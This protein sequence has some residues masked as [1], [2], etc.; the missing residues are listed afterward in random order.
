VALRTSARRVGDIGERTG[1]ARSG[2]CGTGDA[3]VPPNND[4]RVIVPLLPVPTRR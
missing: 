1:V 3:D 4:G 2:E